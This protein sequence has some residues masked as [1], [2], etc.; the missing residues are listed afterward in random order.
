MTIADVKILSEAVGQRTIR[1][2]L[3]RIERRTVYDSAPSVDLQV[4]K[5]Y[6][7]L[8]DEESP[9]DVPFGL[10]CRALGDCQ[11]TTHKEFVVL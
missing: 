3:L 1:F 10:T 2:G 8:C 4:W 7:L 5:Y 6:S 11:R 9:K